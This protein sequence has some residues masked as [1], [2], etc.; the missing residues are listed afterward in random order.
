V[1]IHRIDL[2]EYAGGMARL[3]V[4]CSKG[5]Y[6]RSLARDIARA[7]GTVA[8]LEALTR[9]AVGDFSLDEAVGADGPILESLQPMTP[10]LAKRCAV[11]PEAIEWTEAG[12][13]LR[14]KK[15]AREQ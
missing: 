4:H 3:E 13:F 6:I 10:A 9:T 5:T 7:C 2:L 8:H 14:V 15:P 11:A 1:F 12:E